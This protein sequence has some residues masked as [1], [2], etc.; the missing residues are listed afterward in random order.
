M[1]NECISGYLSSV[2]GKQK[3]DEGRIKIT[4]HSENTHEYYGIHKVWTV[5]KEQPNS[6]VL[7]FHSKGITRLGNTNNVFVRDRAEK[8]IFDIAIRN[9]RYIL[10]WL[11]CLP[12]ITKCGHSPNEGGFIW[13]NFWWVK[14]EHL[15][16]LE[17]PILSEN[18]Y[19]YEEWLIHRTDDIQ[20]NH[21]NC[22]SSVSN[23]P[24]K[25]YNIGSYYNPN[26]NMFY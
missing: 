14:S 21:L 17:E 12:N 25:K 26:T 10:F 20:E 22:L 6:F 13:H 1:T 8:T 11:T 3:Y 18:R 7:Y 9:Y 24:L 19:Y 4:I 2:Y 5:A 23:L 16:R 15:Q